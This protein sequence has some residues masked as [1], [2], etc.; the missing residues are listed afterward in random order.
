[1][2]SD[3]KQNSV[4]KTNADMDR[5]FLNASVPDLLKQLSTE[6]KISLL[7]GKDWWNTIPIPRLN[8]P[9]IKVTDGPNGARGDSFYHMTPA[10]ALPC[11]TSLGAT[12]SKPLIEKAGILLANET[13]ARNAICLL[14]P[15]INIQRSPLGGRAFESFSEDPTLSG[16][17]AAAYVNGLQSQGVSA[18]IK[19]FVGNDQEHERMGED[20]IIAPRPLREIYLRPFQIAQRLSKPRAYMT[21][22]NKVNGTHC[23]ENEWLLKELLRK[24]WG[25][26]GLIMSDWY[27]TY[28]VSE[29]INAGLN[30]E[31]PGEAKWRTQMLV[32]HL[33]Q[34]HKIDPRQLDRVAG[35]VLQWVQGL[36]K[37]N[38]ELVY[39]PPSK[40][41]TRDEAK[42]SDARLLRQLGGEGIVLL[43]N[44]SDILPVVGPKK[45][46]VIGPNAKA[47]V[48]TGGGSAQLRAAW[49][50]TP[51][52]GLEANAPKDVELSY[53]LGAITAKYLPVLGS[54]FT[55]PDGSAG[56]ELRHYAID[57]DGEQVSEPA[58]VE[59]WNNS[60]M[61]MA[62]FS[63]PALGTHFFTE[64]NAVF[65]PPETTE[66]E[67]SLTV[68]GKAWL[69][70][71]DK[72][73]V[74]NSKDQIKGEA[75]FG[76]GTIEK[77]ATIKVEKGKKYTLRMLHDTR[78]P[79]AGATENN[80]PFITKGIRVGAFPVINQDQAIRDAASLAASSDVAVI[81]AG[82]N[83]DWESEGYDRPDLS[84]PLRTN[85]LIEAVAEANPNTVVVIQAGSA[86][87]MP[88]IDQVKGVVYAWYLGNE[89]GNAIADIIY[90][91][92][93]PSGRLPISLPK[94]EKDIA[95]QLNF[96]SART[97]IHYE[98]GIWVGYKGHNAR[99]IEPLFPFGHGL[100]YTTFDY[101]SLKI[102]HPPPATVQTSDE[103]K[104]KVGVTVTNTG[105]K[106]GSH[107]VHFYVSPPDETST[108]LRNPQW[109]LQAFEKVYDLQPGES[110]DVEVVLDKYAVSH[111][112]ELW[113]T[114]RAELGEWTVR[115]GVDAQT[116]KGEAKFTIENDL[117]WRG[118]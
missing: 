24:E 68:T 36:V 15:T 44:D 70:M 79:P 54:E 64:L 47:S 9:S 90:G 98:E 34:A 109:T 105:K 46:A 20:S 77:K 62:D 59:T 4:P 118:L 52:E 48:L 38:E 87:S 12:F 113:N 22:Y 69:W 71:D 80:T 78:P 95:A 57:E 58:V 8:V 81:V 116:M 27:G 50:S 42:E 31:M 29:A 85:E 10:V 65:T 117:E 108:G 37:L 101:E 75:Y 14:A 99:G 66:W 41:K 25:H 40:E 83:S 43:K 55:H 110:R 84:L 103:W 56:F 100:S 3:P 106:T 17:I 74:D 88:W 51:Y 53:W 115:V 7:A 111:W 94:R 72:L 60:D 97:K 76:C 19:H 91:T 89:T 13:K 5:S 33:I 6:E 49:S 63:N 67:F 11:A 93:N 26:D 104:V 21:S 92:Q 102:I 23:S 96:K 28:S 2:R 16:H 86:V 61:L 82:L 112:D 114:W 18:T 35:E 73:V 1:M 107:S 45:I 32:T 39:S 30:L